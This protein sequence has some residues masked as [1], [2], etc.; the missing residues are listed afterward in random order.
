[1]ASLFTDETL[2][3]SSQ[4]AIQIF[5][6]RYQA[7]LLRQQPST[8]MET[9]GE[10][11]PTP[12]PTTKYPMSFLALK[13]SEL[14]DGAGRFQTIGEKDVELNVA[15]FQTGV[16]IEL[17]KLLTNTFSARRWLDAP[18]RMLH[19]EAVFRNRRVATMLEANT[20]LCGWDK[21]ALFHD[22]HLCN[23]SDG[24]SATFD[25]LQATVK[26]VVSVANLEAEIVLMMAGVLD[27]NGDKLGAMP[28]TVGV[29]TQKFQPLVNLLKQDIIANTAGTASIKNPYGDGLLT[30]VHMPELTDVN[31]WFLI[32]SKLIA[33]GVTP[34]VSSKLALPTPGFDALG[35]RRFDENSDSFKKTSKI[36]VSSH[37]WYG[38][39]SLYPHAIRLVKG[40]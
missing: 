18:E 9:L 24:A 31:D 38:E 34:W 39:K 33:M 4:E 28:D 40:A 27:E 13:Y 32:D 30:V 35:L 11:H 22:A 17:M 7:V 21:L 26:D 6:E 1:M 20:D 36:A 5:D 8:W 16:E 37:V 2:P 25:N 10:F 14:K 3:A 29:S 19:A 12:S 23:P 15:E